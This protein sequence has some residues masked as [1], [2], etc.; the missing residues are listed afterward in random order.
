MSSRRTFLKAVGGLSAAGFSATAWANHLAWPG[1]IGLQLLTIAPLLRRD[2]LGGLK[3]AAAIGYKQIELSQQVHIPPADLQRYLKLTGLKAVSGHFP[4]S[5]SSEQWQVQMDTARSLDLQ[6]MVIDF[7]R[8][9]DAEGW[10]RFAERLNGLGRRCAAQQIQFAYHNHFREFQP[11]GDTNGYR[12]LLTHTDP[13][14]VV[15][16]MDLFW[17]TYGQQDPV[18]YFHEFPGRFRLLHLKGMKKGLC[19]KR[20]A[21]P[22]GPP[23]RNGIPFTE[24]GQGCID[25]RRI[26]AHVGEAGAQHVFVEQDRSDDPPVKTM[27]ISYDYVRHLRVS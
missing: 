27:R 26:F 7:G 16:E 1:P 17:I 12:I 10:K 4:S 6:Y 13:K 18:V 25:W 23:P 8:T 24:V 2:P 15:M 5:G 11:V 20:G 3:A 21:F 22:S 14:L 19:S 9:L